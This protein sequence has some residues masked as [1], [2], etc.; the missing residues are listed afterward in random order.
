MPSNAAKAQAAN[1]ANKAA[2]L[3]ASNLQLSSKKR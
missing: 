1:A 2:R 3:P